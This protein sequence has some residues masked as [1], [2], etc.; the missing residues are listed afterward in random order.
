ML[1][2]VYIFSVNK[3]LSVQHVQLEE[4]PL[5]V[6]LKVSIDFKV[7]LYGSPCKNRRAFTLRALVIFGFS[8]DPMSFMT[9]FQKRGAFLFDVIT[10][11]QL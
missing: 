8:S 7:M 4:M 3:F 11:E 9:D 2:F 1:R 5:F 10:S 6:K